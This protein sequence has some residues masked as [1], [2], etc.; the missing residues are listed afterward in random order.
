MLL[1]RKLIKMATERISTG[2]PNLDPF[3]GGGFKKNSINLVAGGPGS[4]KSILAVQFILA[5]I[6]DGE[7][8]IYVTFEEKKKKFYSD[9]LS[10]GFDL[11]KH[12]KSG[13]FVFLEYTPEQVKTILTEGGGVIESVI[14]KKKIKRLV[15]DSMTA[16]TLLYEDELTKKEAALALFELIDKWD[17]TAV[18]TSEDKTTHDNFISAALEFEVD[19]VILL[20]HIKQKGIR[21][22]ALEILKMRGTKTPEK[23]IEMEITEKGL[24]VNP[25]KIEEF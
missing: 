11:E 16:F 4:G 1:R 21:K 20:Y 8:G 12:E 22:R 14:E 18:L 10:L 23:T 25:K 24:V 2:V 3:I 15:I 5:G 17:C 19:G 9:M 13:A 6:K 7:T